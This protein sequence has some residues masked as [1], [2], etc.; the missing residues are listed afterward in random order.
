M[1]ESF[2]AM[3]FA[4]A[5]AAEA[6]LPPPPAPT[7]PGEADELEGEGDTVFPS[8]RAWVEQWM[9]RYAP[10][11]DLWCDDWMSHPE[12]A[13]R[14]WALWQAWEVANYEQGAAMSSWW[15]MHFD[16]HLAVIGAARGPFARCQT[17]GHTDRDPWG[18]R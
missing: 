7:A 13:S 10:R 5:A 6:P 1:S 14:L 11:P 15:L 2:D 12:V 18:R 16:G 3:L 9:T 4:P 8:T 17:A